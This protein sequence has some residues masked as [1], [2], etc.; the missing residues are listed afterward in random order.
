V[1]PVFETDRFI[2][3]RW[4]TDDAEAAFKIYSD[5]EVMAFIG[6]GRPPV[7]SIEAMRSGLQ[8]MIDRDSGTPYGSFPYLEKATGE[9]V[10]AVLLKPLPNSEKVEVGWHLGREH[11]GRGYATETGRAALDYGFNTLGLEK[12]YAVVHPANTASIRVTQRLGMK[13]IGRTT[14]FYDQELEFFELDRPT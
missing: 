3:R 8:R 1:D 7:E 2:V 13:P 9:L 10:G 6:M 5:P 12:I 11:W 14:E 4:M